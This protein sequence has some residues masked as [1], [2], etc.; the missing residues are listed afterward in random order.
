MA[1]I[2]A[3][4]GSV[5]LSH[6]W[7]EPL[8]FCAN[9]RFDMIFQAEGMHHAAKVGNMFSVLDNFDAFLDCNGI[10]VLEDLDTPE[11]GEWFVDAKRWARLKAYKIQ[12]DEDMNTI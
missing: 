5:I 4:R 2:A 10:L 9:C 11:L 1:R 8:S 7:G 12:V 3:E 6:D